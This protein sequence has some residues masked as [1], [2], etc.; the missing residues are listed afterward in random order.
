MRQRRSSQVEPV[1]AA[2]CAAVLAAARPGLRLAA[3]V[4]VLQLAGLLGAAEVRAQHPLPEPFDPTSAIAQ[5]AYAD[6]SAG[7]PVTINGQQLDYWDAEEL[8][9]LTGLK[10]ETEAHSASAHAVLGPPWGGWVRASANCCGTDAFRAE[11]AQAHLT[12]EVLVDDP[13]G[14]PKVWLRARIRAASVPDSQGM[15]A[16]RFVQ[17]PLTG[18]GSYVVRYPEG[19]LIVP[20]FLRPDLEASGETRFDHSSPTKFVSR[21]CD[22][23]AGCEYSTD[24]HTEFDAVV[25]YEAEPGVHFFQLWAWAGR[26]GFAVADPVIEPHPDNPDVV[27]TMRGMDSE[28]V[29]G[30]LADLTPEDLVARGIDPGP[31]ERLGFFEPE[32][33]EP[34]PEPQP[35]PEPEDALA[36]S[37][38]A[39]PTPEPNAN[40]WHRGPVTVALSAADE[41]GGSGV[42]EIHYSTSGASNDAQVVAG[43]SASVVIAEEGETTL[44]YFAVDE[45]GNQEAPQSLTL[46]IDAT[47]PVL[48]GLPAPGCTLK[49]V[50][51]R[52]VEVANVTAGDPLSGPASASLLVTAVSSEPEISRGDRTAPDIVVRGSV[53]QVRAERAK[54]GHGRVYTITARAS[55]LAGNQTTATGS[56]RVPRRNGG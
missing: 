9:G 26:H 42:A 47:P 34:D 48:A 44:T 33:P 35:E 49:P 4:A 2:R 36:P 24:P 53:V 13:Q 20:P 28:P 18:E 14:R 54:R 45:A 12:G 56:C 43:S 29:P 32:E 50:N 17:G 31:F 23:L 6:T 11:S 8:P 46:R 22:P 16:W 37:T 39:S 3:A 19:L 10:A 5:A 55:D 40:G 7:N 30:P 41:T 25:S 1:S 15:A 51:R 27:V 52:L 38:S 21:L